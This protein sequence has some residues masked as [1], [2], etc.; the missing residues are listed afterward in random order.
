MNIKELIQHPDLLNE[1]TLT[2]LEDIVERYPFFQTARI[3]YVANL[4]MLHD[5]NF[6]KELRK[7][8]VFVP[9]RTSLFMLTE[10]VNYQLETS[11]STTSIDTALDANR[12]ISLINSFLSNQKQQRMD[13]AAGEISASDVPSLSDLTTDYASFLIKQ[14]EGDDVEEEEEEESNV[15]KLKG[16]DLIDSFI[17]ETQG[18][19]R[20][21]IAD[22]DDDK[23]FVSPLLSDEEEE[24]YTES[25]VNIYIKQGRYQQALEI[26]RKICLNNPK[27]SANFA[28][29][30][31]LLEVITAN[32]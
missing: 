17:A 22:L 23:E 28:A 27:K 19:Q 26:L 7:A 18:R 6:G 16:A 10:G 32:E 31:Q 14:D 15:P 21:E 5:K 8:S 9:D 13:K 1:Q 30:I 25:M 29:Q 12:T 3:L 2:Q 24:I 4:F 11:E 20:F